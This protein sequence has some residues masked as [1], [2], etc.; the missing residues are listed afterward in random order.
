VETVEATPSLVQRQK[1]LR[2]A[3]HQRIG[4]IATQLGAHPLH[5]FALRYWFR[6][7]A[8]AQWLCYGVPIRLAF[9][10]APPADAGPKLP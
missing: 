1:R 7:C 6:C 4:T 10:F 9:N 2:Y 5:I 3:E 8:A